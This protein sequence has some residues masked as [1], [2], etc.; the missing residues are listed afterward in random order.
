MVHILFIGMTYLYFSR[1]FTHELDKHGE[2]DETEVDSITSSNDALV[3]KL[4][5]VFLLSFKE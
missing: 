4:S 3:L 2:E 5:R 1:Y